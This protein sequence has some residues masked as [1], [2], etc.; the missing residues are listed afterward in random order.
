ML[1]DLIKEYRAE[2]A[3]RSP[4]D[5]DGVRRLH[6][7]SIRILI[8][9]SGEVDPALGWLIDFNDISSVVK[10][11][12][13]RIDHSFLEDL[14]GLDD[15]SLTGLARWIEAQIAPGL[16]GLTRVRVAPVGECRFAPVRLEADPLL[17]LSARIRFTFEAAQQLPHLP[18]GHPCRNLH[19]HTYRVE[20]AAADLDAL[21]PLL[22][23]LYEELDHRCLND[24]PEL[25]EATSERICGWIW[26]RLAPK[27]GGLNAVIVQETETARCIYHGK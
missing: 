21:E 10:P 19:G 3:H 12:V 17:G 9:V 7:H 14:Q 20:V 6:G 16:P 15:C 26:D 11:L 1:V 23:D 5:T 24:F 13:D 22:G 25:T 4:A 18:E 2:V 27:I 8:T